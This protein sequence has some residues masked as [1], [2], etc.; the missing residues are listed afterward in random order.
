MTIVTLSAFEAENP[1]RRS[2]D[3]NGYVAADTYG[4]A[5]TCH[6]AVLHQWMDLVEMK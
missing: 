2:G 5:E 3:L 1:L 4:L 6:A